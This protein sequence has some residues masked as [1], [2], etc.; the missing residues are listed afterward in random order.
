MND[1]SGW[2]GILALL[3]EFMQS[4][5][6][7]AIFSLALFLMAMRKVSQC[8]QRHADCEGFLSSIALICMEQNTLLLHDPSDYSKNRRTPG[9]RADDKRVGAVLSLN[10]KLVALMDDIKRNRGKKRPTI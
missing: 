7:I 8:E 5:F 10:M 9:R 1:A 3:N 6:A 2:H 4:N